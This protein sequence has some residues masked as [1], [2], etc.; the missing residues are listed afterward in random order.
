MKTA[1]ILAAGMGTR[2]KNLTRNKPKAFLVLD[3][4][5]IIEES[6]IKLLELGIERIIIGTGY[7]AGFF[8]ELKKKYPEI[9]CKLNAKYAKTG[10]M[11]TL[12]NLASLIDSDFI[13]LESDLIY[14]KQG[15]KKLI[16]DE[17][18]NIVLASSFTGAG[19][20]VYIECNDKN[21]LVNMSKKKTELKSVD[22]ELVGITKI[23]YSAYKT[24]CS[25][26]EQKFAEF[27]GLDYEQVLVE[28]SKQC[29][30]KVKRL[31]NYAWCEIDNEEHLNYATKKIY[32]LIKERGNNEES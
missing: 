31:E 9:E 7:L 28:L 14:D 4:K 32:P 16:A 17:N 20:E 30:V 1:V 11:Y 23:S 24:S 21:E 8:E 10:S 13:L 12:F 15:I 26:A 25:I 22:A 3:E 6:I 18:K 19:D 2:L 29:S 5:P 27:P